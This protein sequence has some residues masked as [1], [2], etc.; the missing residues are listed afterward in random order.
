[1]EL[2]SFIKRNRMAGVVLIVPLKFGV[3][4]GERYQELVTL[5]G[6]K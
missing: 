5:L 6:D 1:M 4:D 2:E 3:S